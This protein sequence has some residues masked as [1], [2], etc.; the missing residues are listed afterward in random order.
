MDDRRDR[1]Q[2][3]EAGGARLFRAPR[4]PHRDRD[5]RARAVEQVPRAQGA[6]CCRPSG[7]GSSARCR[8][9]RASFRV[10]M[11]C[12]EDLAKWF[13]AMGHGYQARM[14]AVLRAYMLAV[15]GREIASPAGQGLEG[16]RDLISAALCDD[17]SAHFALLLASDRSGPRPASPGPRSRLSSGQSAGPLRRSASAE[18]EGVPP[19]PS[20]SKPGAGAP[21]GREIAAAPR[22]TPAAGF[23]DGRSRQAAPYRRDRAGH[24]R[25]PAGEVRGRR[26][27]VCDTTDAGTARQG[28]R[29]SPEWPPRPAAQRSGRDE[30]LGDRGRCRTKIALAA[31]AMLLVAGCAETE[32]NPD[33]VAGDADHR[34]RHGRGGRPDH[35]RGAAARQRRRHRPSP[36]PPDPR[37][38]TSRR[39]PPAT[40]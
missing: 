31:L 3:H 18:G 14:N 5:R 7:T 28:A 26:P 38:A 23:V 13:R 37:S 16:R 9:G 17:R 25:N 33:R 8:S 35:A 4:P 20:L 40:R 27:L 30:K 32:P 19:G 6:T 39:S 29:G 21:G 11:T 15:K 36:S 24:R 1:A 34:Q 12:D 10:T 2:A 22:R